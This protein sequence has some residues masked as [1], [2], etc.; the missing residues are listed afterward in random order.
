MSQPLI[1]AN[2]KMNLDLEE[3]R[4]WCHA[5]ESS[6]GTSSV[7]AQVVVC[8]SFLHMLFLSGRLL[9]VGFL[10]GAQDCASHGNGAYTGD[11]S[12]AMLKD[13][14][15]AYVI[16]GHSERRMY[17]GEKDALIHDKMQQVLSHGMIP[18]LCVGETL[19][20]RQ[21]GLTQKT[22][23]KQIQNGL[24]KGT[25]QSCVI[26]YEPVWAIGTGNVPQ[27]I[28]IEKAHSVIADLVTQ[29]GYDSQTPVL[30]GGSVTST[31]AQALFDIP[32]VDGFLVGGASLDGA[33]FQKIMNSCLTRLPIQG[34]QEAL[35][36]RIS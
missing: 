27:P 10:L 4:R 3:V 26:A 20:E 23:T 18:V 31:N 7:G 24:P 28:E 29:M 17:H 34:V 12:A 9:E 32:G 2:W 33:N 14:G 35:S 6:W 25:G 21:E 36:S 5:F 8:P 15:C 16:V 19:E 13:A 22:L 30:Y 1:I 11:V